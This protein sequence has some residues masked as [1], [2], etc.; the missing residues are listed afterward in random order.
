MRRLWLAAAALITLSA[1]DGGDLPPAYR[2]LLVPE[3]RLAS[4]QALSRGPTPT[5]RD[6]MPGYLVTVRTE[7]GGALHSGTEA[8]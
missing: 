6:R 1:C 3:E 8:S 5:P 4:G 2:D 7:T